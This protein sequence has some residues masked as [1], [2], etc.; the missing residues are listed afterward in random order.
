MPSETLTCPYCNSQFQA[1]DGPGVI[2]P[3]CQEVLPSRNTPRADGAG[4]APAPTQPTR[5]SNRSVLTA[6]LAAMIAMA[7]L[8]LVFIIWTNVDRSRRHARAPT[9]VEVTAPAGL[10]SLGYLPADCDVV[11]GLHIAE[12]LEQPYGRELLG[13]F[14][15]PVGN[16]GFDFLEQWTG[17]PLEEIDHA[18][19]GLMTQTGVFPR[20]TL[21]VQTRRPVDTRKLTEA[22]KAGGSKKQ[23]SKKYYPLHV[24]IL[25]VGLWVTED[26]SRLIVTSEFALD[27]VPDAPNPG[28][29]HLLP[30]IR[31]FLRERAPGTQ[32]WVVG[33]IE[34][35]EKTGLAG[36]IHVGQVP[37]EGKALTRLRDLGLWL[38]LGQ[39]VE[40]NARL[41]GRDAAAA[42]T[43]AGLVEGWWK[44]GKMF[45]G[46]AEMRLLGQELSENLRTEK[47]DNTVT[48]Q[49]KVSG[50]ALRKALS[51]PEPERK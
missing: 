40:L 39:D 16:V 14:R 27:Q 23:G 50:A 12:L 20:L 29:T 22:L 26:D 5:R 37:E 32:L 15:L 43:L 1:S 48:L 11:L 13:R 25:Q 47:T 4:F 46:R 7:A 36:L 9:K 6:L 19:L 44:G 51:P 31:Q 28:S 42:A 18:V 38:R 2:C 24:G 3:R 34:D 17:V 10:S 30:P 33:H 8:G 49:T 41:E 35:W 21:V 45:G